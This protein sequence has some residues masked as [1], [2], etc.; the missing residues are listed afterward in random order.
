MSLDTNKN[1][2]ENVS[3]THLSVVR[4]DTDAFELTVM[5]PCDCCQHQPAPGDA[6]CESCGYP[7]NGNEDERNSFISDRNYKHLELAEID[8]KVRKATNSLYVLAAFTVVMGIIY[9]AATAEYAN[10][11]SVLTT[12]LVLAAIYLGLALWSKKQA[13][14]AIL[15]G[16]I[17]FSVIQVVNMIVDPS[18]IV[19]GIIVKVAVIIYLIKGVQSAF[20]AQK[21]KKELNLK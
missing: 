4:S 12:N 19:K 9:Y 7:L 13:V 1:T 11:L 10:P 6:F 20:D 15:S 17:L 14:A 2:E 18:T 16:L 5:A 8:T 21:I 3:S